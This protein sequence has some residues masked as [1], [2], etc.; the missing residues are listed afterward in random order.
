MRSSHWALPGGVGIQWE[1]VGVGQ[2]PGEAR[3]GGDHGGVVG[4]EDR[5]GNMCRDG[6]R[7]ETAA[8]LTVGGDAAAN[9]ETVQPG[10]LERLSVTRSM[11]W[12]TIADW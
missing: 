1:I 6:K 8:Q 12:S 11:R 2:A 7:G 5:R 4:A 3:S 10:E 9:R